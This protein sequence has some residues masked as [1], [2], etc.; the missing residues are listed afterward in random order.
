ML[1][2]NDDPK[3]VMKGVRHGAVDY[4]LKP[5]RIEEL[6]NI[7]QHVIRKSQSSQQKDKAV[8]DS[9]AGEGGSAP[10]F[11]DGEGNA[12]PEE[13]KTRKRKDQYSTGNADEGDDE[14][15]SDNENEDSNTNKRPRVVWSPDLHKK[16]VAAVEQL[17]PDSESKS[18]KIMITFIIVCGFH[19]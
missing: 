7:W 14:D 18:Y 15:A 6:K 4:L 9:E 5:V 12:N 11:M 1:S 3:L 13:M 17:G 8:S 16:F 19:A 10:L 2:A